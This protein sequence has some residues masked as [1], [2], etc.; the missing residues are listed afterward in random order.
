MRGPFEI[1]DSRIKTSCALVEK[2]R[3]EVDKWRERNYLG[4]SKTT[5]RLLH[6]WFN[7][8]H[9]Q[10]NHSFKYYFC[11]REAIETLIYLFEIKKV[12]SLGNLIK[13]FDITKKLAYNPH[14]DLFAKYCFKMATGSGKTK[15]MS[16]AIVWNYFNRIL[17]NNG[18]CSKNF[19]II[20]PNITVYERLKTDFESCK[21]FR[22]DP[23]IPEEFE[24]YWDMEAVLEDNITPH[25]T[26]GRI[27]L[28]NVQKLY[29]RTKNDRTNPVQAIIGKQPTD[30]INTFEAI[31]GDISSLDEITI[32][33]DEAHHVWD[34][35][36]AWYKIIRRFFDE[37]KK[38]KKNFAMQ[39]DFSAT[40]K[41]QGT[42]SLFEWCVVDYSL[43]DAINAGVVK[44]PIIGEVENAKEVPSQRAD[45]VYRDYIEAGIR[46]WAKYK[47]AMQKV[48]K[49]PIIFFMA[50]NTTEADDIAN[51]LDTRSEFKGKVLLIHT[52]LKGEISDKEWEKLKEDSKQLDGNNDKH[53]AVVSV[54]MLREGWDVKG[55]NVVVGLR[56]FTSKA[57]ILP[58]QTLG[59]GLRLL[60]GP[61]S[62]F[63]ETV[64]IFGSKAFVDYIDAELK[65]EGLKLERMKERELPGMTNVFVDPRKA[66]Y[67]IIIPILTPKYTRINRSFNDINIALLPKGAFDID[68]KSYSIRKTA[69]GREALTSKLVWKDEWDQPIPE[70]FEA[71]VAYYSNIILRE[72][73]IPSR[74]HEFIPKLD[75]YIKTK[76]FTKKLT[77]N[78]IRDSRFLSQLTERSILTYLLTLFPRVINGLTIRPQEVKLSKDE[79]KASS[80]E[81][82]LTRKMSTE[83][84]K[85]ILNLVP[86]DNDL[87]ERF[88]EL[89]NSVS[90]VKSFIKNVPNLNFYIEFVND[91]KGISYYQPDFVVDCGKNVYLIETKGAETIDVVLK[92]KRAIEWCKDIS[93]LTGKKWKYVK[94]KQEIFDKNQGVKTLV[95]LVE[96][97]EAYQAASSY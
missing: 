4:A 2:L 14:E 68:L 64:D 44:K 1:P 6:F 89:L 79:K 7:E 17:E 95:K 25:S 41:R 94:V 85:C 82:F 65:K 58:E 91:K 24:S 29:E 39:L 43:A 50:N 37:Y 84:K 59:R 67:D 20:A 33:N 81:P 10:S 52:N 26:K 21:V 27:Y 80:I 13:N 18:N 76:L 55:V 88:C 62:G 73:K 5:L 83:F 78:T 57:N 42:G 40:P 3:V 23:L 48:N 28:T 19:L 90:D 87:E 47:T 49:H 74:T 86:I 36:L 92:D 12:R 70:N 16:L 66:K 45:I 46:R 31:Y 22:A 71:I 75:E 51:Y 38:L 77:E 34:E 54:L 72:C 69:I 60:F 61:E 11:Q 35:D 15:I 30:G 56:P 9:M 96:L 8:D 93:N 32:I 63:D 53:R 97:I